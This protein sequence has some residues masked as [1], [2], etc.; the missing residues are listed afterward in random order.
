[1]DIKIV[2]TADGSKTLTAD[3]SGTEIF[4]SRHGALQESIYVFIQHGLDTYK[5][6]AKPVRVLEVGFGTGLNALLGMQWAKKNQVNVQ[7][8]GLEPNRIGLDI[9]TELNYPELL[10]V[11]TSDFQ[12]LHTHSKIETPAFVGTVE[13]IGIEYFEPKGTDFDLCWYDAFSPRYQPQLWTAD[14]FEKV[15]NL[16][17]PG[18]KLVTYSAKGDVQRALK[19]TGFLVEKL[20]GPPGKREMLRATKPV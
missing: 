15:H 11:T 9:I 8:V 12:D 5:E 16:L 17:A 13:D 1:M 20:P 3:E 19:A 18:G 2:L 14:I 7:Y 10:K 6:T 4:H